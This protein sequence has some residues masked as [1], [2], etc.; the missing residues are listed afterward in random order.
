MRLRLGKDS[1][2]KIEPGQPLLFLH[3]GARCRP[4][5][6][7]RCNYMGSPGQRNRPERGAGGTAGDG[8]PATKPRVSVAAGYW[9]A[10]DGIVPAGRL[11]QIKEETYAVERY[12]SLT[13]Y[14]SNH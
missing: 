10:Y 8:L 6:R 7:L 2:L 9:K 11:V 1:V 3:A 14:L 5:A 4:C 12:D 13:G